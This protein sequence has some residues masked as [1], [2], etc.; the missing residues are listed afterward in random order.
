MRLW[1][2][3]MIPVLPRQHLLELHREIC[4]MRGKA[5]GYI[6]YI[7]RHGWEYLYYYHTLVIKEMKARGY[8]PD[9]IWDDYYYRGKHCR[10]THPD[11]VCRTGRK[12]IYPEHNQI[13]KTQCIDNL[14]NKLRQAPAGKYNETELY[15][16][17]AW[18]EENS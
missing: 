13:Y 6:D 10:P 7:P 12:S 2:Y 5:W 17:W 11:W 9:P 18:V 14:S 16:F 3:K 1:H 4:A 8:K 15:R